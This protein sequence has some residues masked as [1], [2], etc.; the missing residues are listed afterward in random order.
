MRPRLLLNL[1]HNLP[2]FSSAEARAWEG[3]RFHYSA[4]LKK[5]KQFDN[6]FWLHVPSVCALRYSLMAPTSLVSFVSLLHIVGTI[7]LLMAPACS[8]GFLPHSKSWLSLTHSCPPGHGSCCRLLPAAEKVGPRA[9]LLP[10]S[11]RAVHERR[12]AHRRYLWCY[13][14]HETYNI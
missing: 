11:V 3:L 10:K 5:H 8:V 9:S 14:Y 12:Q 4:A 1:I 13:I 2:H 6:P 7:I